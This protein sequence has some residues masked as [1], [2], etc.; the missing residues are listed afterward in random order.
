MKQPLHNCVVAAIIIAICC[1]Y[2][3]P[4]VRERSIINQ[5]AVEGG[6]FV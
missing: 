4:K 6:W 2:G 3:L 5:N 1:D